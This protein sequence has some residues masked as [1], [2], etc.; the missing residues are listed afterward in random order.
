M[1]ISNVTNT[2]PYVV[3]KLPAARKSE[4]DMEA[5][6]KL[7]TVQLANQNPLEPMNDRD[8]FAQMAQLGQV[9]G[10]D[11]LNKQAQLEQAQNLMGK[12]VTAVRP[13]TESNTGENE[14]VTGVVSKLNVRN[15]QYYVGIKEADGGIVEVQMNNIQ[16]VTPQRNVSDYLP[17]VGRQVSGTIVNGTITTSI[18]G[19]VKGV[20]TKDGQIVLR[21]QDGS[22][23]V[24]TLPLERLESVS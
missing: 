16:A 18:A 13:M 7:L 2:S 15:G 4:L 17:L 11:Q 8:F 9:Q 6:L 21:V 19:E 23:K 3:P 14:L 5:F 1:S 10:M 12:E 24:Q 20:E 22:G